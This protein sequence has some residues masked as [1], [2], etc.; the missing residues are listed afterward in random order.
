MKIAL[1]FF[2][3]QVSHL[4]EDNENVVLFGNHGWSILIDGVRRSIAIDHF[5]P[6]DYTKEF[7]QIID[8]LRANMPTISRWNSRG[9][10]YELLLRRAARQVLCIATGLKYYGISKC[11]MSTSVY[12]HLDSTILDLAGR[13][14]SVPR[15]YLAFN[16]ITG[17]L[18]PLNQI[19]DIVTRKVL[20]Y[21]ISE[22]DAS[23]DVQ[24]FSQR[25]K[26]NHAPKIGQDVIASNENNYIKA[27]FFSLYHDLR[28]VFRFT[29]NIL[30]SRK[31][32][33]NNDFAYTTDSYPFQNLNQVIAQRKALLY[34]EKKLTGVP[35]PVNP[36]VN[37]IIM[38]HFQPEA[39]SFP[40]G[41]KLCNHIDIIYK[42]RSLGYGD[43]LYYKEHFAS[44]FYFTSVGATQVGAYRNI[45]YY[46]HLESLNCL[47]VKDVAGEKY[48]GARCRKY[49]PVT[50]TGTV[51]VERALNGLHTIVTGFPWYK[52]LPGVIH[53]DDLADLSSL[54]SDLLLFN[55]TIAR[56]SHEFLVSLLSNKTLT[57]ASGIGLTGKLDDTLVGK[58]KCEFDKLL[59][60]F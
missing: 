12:H 13:L 42:L 39:S 36:R 28:S 30:I 17:H 32:A 18:L 55:E 24:A 54:S 21:E 23:A 43:K 37:L 35:L 11:M 6:L 7:S 40:E 34:C 51:A 53:I 25:S 16:I 38:A 27:I 4:Y 19:E 52:G 3:K 50:I 29:R 41:G 44:S 22:Y 45:D 8:T 1:C 56:E 20:N 9:D 2:D 59:E 15:I 60:I 31:S 58:F 26:E 14:A 33:D 10:T 48:G 46:K 57:N 49:L 5:Q 47:F